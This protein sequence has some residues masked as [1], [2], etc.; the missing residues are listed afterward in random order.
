LK[1]PLK[2]RQ[3]SLLNLLGLNIKIPKKLNRGRGPRGAPLTWAAIF[4]R[5]KFP[6]IFTLRIDFSSAIYYNKL[7]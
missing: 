1:R 6:T 7:N 2:T 4:I 3:K 5:H